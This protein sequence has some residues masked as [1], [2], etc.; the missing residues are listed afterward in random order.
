MGIP[1]VSSELSFSLGQW[2]SPLTTVVDCNA[3]FWFLCKLPLIIVVTATSVIDGLGPNRSA[4]GMRYEWNVA[5]RVVRIRWRRPIALRQ[6]K[7]APGAVLA[8]GNSTEFS[9][10]IVNCAVK[11]DRSSTI[12]VVW[13]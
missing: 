12:G 13:L 5:A 1:D 10:D 9:S 3:T 4:F 2:V 7:G 6:Q 8:P 11:H